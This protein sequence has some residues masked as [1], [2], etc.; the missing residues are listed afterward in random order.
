MRHDAEIH[1]IAQFTQAAPSDVPAGPGPTLL[2]LAPCTWLQEFAT[3]S[4]ITARVLPG[5][6]Y[7]L[8]TCAGRRRSRDPAESR[9]T[10]NIGQ[11]PI[12]NCTHTHAARTR[13]HTR[14]HTHTHTHT[15]TRAAA[16]IAISDNGARIPAY[17]SIRAQWLRGWIVFDLVGIVFSGVMIV[18]VSFRAC[19]SMVRGRGSRHR[20]RS[21][22][23]RQKQLLP[24]RDAARRFARHFPLA[25]TAASSRAEETPLA[26]HPVHILI[27]VSFLGLGMAAPFVFTLGYVWVDTFRPQDVTWYILNQ[28]PVAMIMGSLH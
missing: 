24:S 10:C 8:R 9:D 16:G 20:R 17:A 5:A 14:T 21:R 11:L 7:W 19:S 26:P 3:R 6:G 1:R 12:G 13:A 2:G 27:Y 22:L 4:A 23:Q 15:H 18:F 28:M 25:R